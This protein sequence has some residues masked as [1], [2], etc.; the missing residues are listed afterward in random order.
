MANTFKAHDPLNPFTI[1]SWHRSKESQKQLTEQ[2][3]NLNFH[4]IC[5][6]SK[7]KLVKLSFSVGQKMDFYK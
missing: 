7:R 2:K 3:L 5:L 6:N 1:Q 4:I